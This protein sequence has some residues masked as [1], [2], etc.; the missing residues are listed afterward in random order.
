MIGKKT[1]VF[2]LLQDLERQ[3]N[4]VHISDFALDNKLQQEQIK[5]AR[6]I[7]SAARSIIYASQYDNLDAS[8]PFGFNVTLKEFYQK[9]S[10]EDAPELGL[11][12]SEVATI[13]NRDLDRIES[14]LDFIEKLSNLNKESQLKEQRRTSVTIYS[15]TLWVM[16]IVSYILKWLM[17][18]HS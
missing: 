14:K 2:D 12:D 13:M 17:E 9:N 16:R 1:N 18:N 3:F 11:I 5:D 4:E 7:I 8:N 10:I 15:M 6:K